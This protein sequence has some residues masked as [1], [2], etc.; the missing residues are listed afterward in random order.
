MNFV[1]IW[2]SG[3][4]VVS[5]SMV[6]THPFIMRYMGDLVWYF[7]VVLL[8]VLAYFCWIYTITNKNDTSR[9]P[10]SVIVKEM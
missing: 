1:G 10:L 8:P 4:A 6:F 2:H 9:T 5:F 3:V 7:G